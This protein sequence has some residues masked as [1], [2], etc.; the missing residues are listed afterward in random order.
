[1]FSLTIIPRFGETD[2]LGHINN[3]TLPCWF[4]RARNPLYKIFNPAMNLKK[5]NLIMARMEFDFLAELFLDKEV[6]IKTYIIKIGNSSIHIGQEAWQEGRLKVKGRNVGVYYDFA[7][8]KSVRVPDDLREKLK[9]HIIS[10]G[11]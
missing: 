1:M 5:W 4:E 2:V 9:E 7:A 6:E 8:K 10:E 11:K 3:T